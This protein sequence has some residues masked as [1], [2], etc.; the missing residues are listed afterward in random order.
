M[1]KNLLLFSGS[2]D[3]TMGEYPK[4]YDL[5][6]SEAKE[7][8]YNYVQLLNW[9]GQKSSNTKGVFSMQNALID[10]IPTIQK[11]NELK[12]SFDIIAFSW[13]CGVALRSLQ[14]FEHLKYLNKIILWGITPYWKEYE[15]MEINKYK[16]TIDA[17]NY[18]GCIV[19]N[20]Y[21]KH[22]VPVEYLL[23]NYNRK[24]QLK[25]GAGCKG[26]DNIFLKYVE[27]IIENPLISFYYLKNI[28]HVVTSFDKDY[29]NFMFN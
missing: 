4:R 27:N 10:A 2:S 21:F 26:G 29:I 6:I 14:S 7:R 8:G 23:H 16:S 13:G 22:Q 19:D 20:D 11:Y 15:V 28:G 5:I 18:C 9:I 25:I 3:P 1:E 12:H 24:T 17:Y